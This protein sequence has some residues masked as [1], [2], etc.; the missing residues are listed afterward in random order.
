MKIETREQLLAKQ[1][2]YHDSLNSQRKQILICAGTGCVAGGSLEI[3]AKMKSLKRKDSAVP[4]LWKK[5]HTMKAS[6]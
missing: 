6:D 1:K 2:E 3:Y 4:F 5:N